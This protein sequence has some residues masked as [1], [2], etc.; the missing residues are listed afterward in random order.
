MNNGTKNT[1]Q[2]PATS[3]NQGGIAEN[4]PAWRRRQSL[5]ILLALVGVGIYWFSHWDSERRPHHLLRPNVL[6][7]FVITDF[8]TQA[9]GEDGKLS[10]Q[11]SAHK[12][13]HYEQ[14]DEAF[15]DEP[16]FR[17]SATK[18]RGGWKA[19]AQKGIAFN[20]DEHGRRI[21]LQNDVKLVSDGPP[22]SAY[23]IKTDV[24]DLFPDI[25]LA[26]TYSPVSI[27]Q[28]NHLLTSIGLRAD[29]GRG[30]LLL[31]NEVHSHYDVAKP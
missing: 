2:T 10:Y 17:V 20:A 3:G 22:T 24:L 9:Y 1:A 23:L 15:L 5:F 4:D 8:T 31:Q 27:T 18:T 21:S 7:D 11:I 6:P 12:L 28:A 30:E 19:T 25:K 13:T 29:W 14:S 26:R 16:H